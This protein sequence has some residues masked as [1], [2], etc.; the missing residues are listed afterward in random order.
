MKPQT[1]TPGKTGPKDRLLPYK[2]LGYLLYAEDRP[3]LVN[4]KDSTVRLITGDAARFF[5]LRT[6]QL[7]EALYW[8]E[9]F[10]LIAKVEK[11]R[12][13]GSAIIHLVPSNRF[14]YGEPNE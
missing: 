4:K 14:V 3:W 9:Q 7:W 10:K 11:E 8:L 12:K 2:V 5:R 6:A 1:P 13:K